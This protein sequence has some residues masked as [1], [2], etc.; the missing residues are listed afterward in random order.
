MCEARCG[1]RRTLQRERKQSK[2]KP[3][4]PVVLTATARN[5]VGGSISKRSLR[6]QQHGNTT[7]EDEEP[8]GKPQRDESLARE[9]R[10]TRKK[11][12]R[13][14]KGK[15]TRQEDSEQTQ[16]GRR[17]VKDLSL[18]IDRN[19]VKMFSGYL[20]EIFV[21]HNGR[22]LPYILDPNFE[23]QLPVIPAQ[24]ENV[25]FTWRSGSKKYKYTFDYLHSEAEELLGVP[26]L[27]IPSHGTV[28]RKPRG[29]DPECDQKCQNGGICDENQQ[30]QCPEGYM[31]QYCAMALCYP[32]CLNGGYCTT[33]GRCSC[34]PGFQGRHCEGGIGHNIKRSHVKVSK[35]MQVKA[36]SD[37]RSRGRLKMMRGQDDA[38]CH[39]TSET[40]HIHLCFG[41]QSIHPAYP[42]IPARLALWGRAGICQNK[43]KNGGKCVQKDRCKCRRGYFG[44]WCQYSQCFVACIN[45]GKC[46]GVN[47]CRCPPGFAGDH[48]EV[49][50]PLGEA[51]TQAPKRCRR[52]CR[53]GGCEGADC[54][55]HAGYTGRWCRRQPQ[56]HRKGLC[57]WV[58]VPGAPLVLWMS[59]GVGGESEVKV[60]SSLSD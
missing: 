55:C 42:A 3:R 53:H 21:I 46:R 29:P 23:K 56:G 10:G 25:N 39:M 58:G 4:G 36:R 12:R 26:T 59:Q 19:Q 57:G 37:Q 60:E 34:P 44:N 52:R 22:V 20:M 17:R 50:L 32:Q 6:S 2:A 47:K 1:G 5:T 41:I 27:S 11:K 8:L 45:G 49:V 51:A 35:E 7:L 31:G 43:C 33:P 24:V 54:Q 14:R 48:C 28:P 16:R 9:G 38:K 18:W 15:V 40:W 30:C 13:R